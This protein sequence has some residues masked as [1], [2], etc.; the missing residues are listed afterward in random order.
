MKTVITFSCLLVLLIQPVKLTATP[1]PI[2]HLAEW[3][4]HM[5]NNAT[6]IAAQLGAIDHRKC[7]RP[8][9]DALNEGLAWYYDGDRVFRQIRA[10]RKTTPG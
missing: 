8:G 10:I 7:V 5:T 3:E 1:P 2:P 6:I 4:A 9:C